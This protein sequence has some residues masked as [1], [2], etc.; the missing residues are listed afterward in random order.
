MSC[1]NSRCVYVVAF[2][3]CKL[4]LLTKRCIQLTVFVHPLQLAQNL[5]S[6]KEWSDYSP[7]PPKTILE[8]LHMLLSHFHHLAGEHLNAQIMLQ[9]D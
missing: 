9:Q 7:M 5:Y 8:V 3:N 1:V 6:T 2:Y 4:A